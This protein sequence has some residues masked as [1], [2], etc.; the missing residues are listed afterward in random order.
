MSAEDREILSRRAPAATWLSPVCAALPEQPLHGFVRDRLRGAPSRPSGVARWVVELLFRRGHHSIS[1]R[2]PSLPAD[3]D[4][5]LSRTA[6]AT[7]HT[8]RGAVRWENC[9]R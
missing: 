2:S 4:P 3:P 5:G 1:S 7:S 9:S 8:A 6:A